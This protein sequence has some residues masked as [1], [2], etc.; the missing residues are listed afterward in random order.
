VATFP[1]ANAGTAIRG[2]VEE[3]GYLFPSDLQGHNPFH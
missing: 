3:R 1:N 2:D